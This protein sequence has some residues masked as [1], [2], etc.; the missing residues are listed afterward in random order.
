MK[1]GGN[2]WI[3]FQLNSRRSFSHSVIWISIFDV[4]IRYR[5]R[6]KYNAIYGLIILCLYIMELY[7]LIGEKGTR[8]SSIERIKSFLV[9]NFCLISIDKHW[10]QIK[11]VYRRF[12]AKS[13]LIFPTKYCFFHL[14]LFFQLVVLIL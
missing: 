1:C 14:F 8:H 11:S 13:I 3:E 4:T 5:I 9:V 12:G 2:N 6:Y 7:L 10:D